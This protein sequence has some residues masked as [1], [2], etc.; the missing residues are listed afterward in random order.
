MGLKYGTLTQLAYAKL[1]K[2][3]PKKDRDEMARKFRQI[4]KERFTT[5]KK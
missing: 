1:E 5:K 3:R 2:H 4:R